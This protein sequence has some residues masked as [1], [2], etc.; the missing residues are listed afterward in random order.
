LAVAKW[1]WLTTP[2]ACR[3]HNC[4][5][6]PPTAQQPCQVPSRQAGRQAGARS[7]LDG[8]A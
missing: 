3:N 5:T 1:R 7:P 8:Q 2:Q 4:T 6:R